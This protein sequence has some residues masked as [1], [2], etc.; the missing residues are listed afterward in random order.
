MNINKPMWKS[1]AGNEFF[2]HANWRADWYNVFESHTSIICPRCKL[3]IFTSPSN[4]LSFS[5]E[6]LFVFFFISFDAYLSFFYILTIFFPL[7]RAFLIYLFLSLSLP[8]FSSFLSSRA[9]VLNSSVCLYVVEQSSF[10]LFRSSV[11][12]RDIHASR[13]SLF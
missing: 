2:S 13:G 9:P 8:V 3:N 11:T 5:M 1:D 4:F 12:T 10:H 7:C 6:H